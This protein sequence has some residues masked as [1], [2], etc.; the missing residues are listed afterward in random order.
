MDKVV[1]VAVGTYEGGLLVYRVDLENEV[2]LRYF[3][4]K[5][6]Q[7]ATAEQGTLKSILFCG[8]DIYTGGRDESVRV[9]NSAKKLQ[10]GVLQ[11]QSG[12]RG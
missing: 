12:R 2:H 3:S 7:V 4:S 5:D 8:R 6:A 9:Y 1:T 10:E 11:A